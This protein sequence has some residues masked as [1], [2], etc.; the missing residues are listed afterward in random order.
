MITEDTLRELMSDTELPPSLAPEL[1]RRRARTLRRNRRTGLAGGVALVLPALL[2]GLAR[3]PYGQGNPAGSGRLAAVAG[4]GSPLPV[5]ADGLVA[6]KIPRLFAWTD[7]E[8]VCWGPKPGDYKPGMA[9]YDLPGECLTSS[10]QL[11]GYSAGGGV[12]GS[13]SVVPVARAEFVLAGRTIPAQVVGFSRH[14]QWRTLTASIDPADELGD[15]VVVRGW[16]AAGRQVL[17]QCTGEACPAQPRPTQPA[18]PPDPANPAA[19]AATSAVPIGGTVAVLPDL[20]VA[21][22]PGAEAWPTAHGV[23]VGNGNSSQCVTDGDTRID[24]GFAIG[25]G[26]GSTI[27]GQPVARAEF[28]VNG[29]AVPAGVVEFASHPQWRVV[30]ADVKLSTWAGNHVRLRGW[31]SDGKLA[32][33][34]DPSQSVRSMPPSTG[35]TT[36]VR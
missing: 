30:I 22:L 33:D 18:L 23:C 32:V 27:L 26:V 1:V 10:D 8:A 11:G 34:A 36:P 20:K 29:V 17:D 9:E 7:S 12:I 24:D 4:D 13:F 19:P 16:D 3:V 31:D 6:L 15:K 21:V 2:V 5:T 14:A 35:T 28:T 25:G